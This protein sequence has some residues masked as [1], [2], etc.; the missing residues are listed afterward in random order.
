MRKFIF[1]LGL[2]FFIALASNAQRHQL[3]P[4]NGG[5]GNGLFEQGGVGNGR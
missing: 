4:E 3:T 1:L 2:V 5:V